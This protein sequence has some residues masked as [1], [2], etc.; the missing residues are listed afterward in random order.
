[1]LPKAAK[2]LKGRRETV[3]PGQELLSGSFFHL[4]NHVCGE[5]GVRGQSGLWLELLLGDGVS[6][7]HLPSLFF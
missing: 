1:M 2:G 7:F 6:S 5:K 4:E 3:K